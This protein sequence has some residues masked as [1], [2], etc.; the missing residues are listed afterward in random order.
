MRAK[1]EAEF[2]EYAA[3]TMSSMHY[4][5]YLSCG[6]WHRAEDVVQVAYEKLYSAWGRAHRSNLNA[7]TRR[8][9][10]NN[11]ISQSQ[12]AWRQREKPRAQLPDVATPQREDA[13]ADDRMLLLRALAR[14]PIRQRAT[15]VLRFWEDLSVKQTAEILNCSESTVKSQT[16]HGVAA[17]RQILN[18]SN[19]TPVR[20]VTT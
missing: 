19:S 8:I 11:L 3:A 1:H 20:E 4:F 7:Y 2:R 12:R 14:L 9:I 5:A 10:V 16:S 6:D 15:V 18:L 13:T 17:L